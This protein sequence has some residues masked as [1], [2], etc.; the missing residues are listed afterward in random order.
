MAFPPRPLPSDYEEL[1]LGFVLAE[2]EEYVRDYEV[3]E[4]P[5]VVL[6]VMLLN[7]AVKLGTLHGW[8]I[9]VMESALK[10]LR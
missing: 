8:M 7:D 5:Q 4:L 6:L 3:P 10:E 9:G 2:A 1:C